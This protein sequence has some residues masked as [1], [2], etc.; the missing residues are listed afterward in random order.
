MSYVT[1]R[2]ISSDLVL[3]GGLCVRSRTII[4]LTLHSRS[5]LSFYYIGFEFKLKV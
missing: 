4:A 1:L 3:F 2:V 5:L